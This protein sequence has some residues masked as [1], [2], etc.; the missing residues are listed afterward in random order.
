MINNFAFIT[1]H[2][3]STLKVHKMHFVTSSVPIQNIARGLCNVF[4]MS[5]MGAEKRQSAFY[6]H[7]FKYAFQRFDLEILN[8]PIWKDLNPFKIVPAVQEAGRIFRIGLVL[9]IFSQFH[10]VDLLAIYSEGHSFRD[11]CSPMS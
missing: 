9:S 1:T 4:F 5:F 3:F 2:D 6:R 11:K 10:S 7:N 8:H